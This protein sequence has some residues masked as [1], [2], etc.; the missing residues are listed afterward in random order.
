MFGCHNSDGA[1]ASNGSAQ[2]SSW[3]KAA[4]LSGALAL[5][6]H[7]LC[8][9]GL[10]GLGIGGY[11]IHQLCWHHESA[12]DSSRGIEI[13]RLPEIPLE[14]K[15]FSEERAAVAREALIAAE[16]RFA[17]VIEA[18]RLEA[19]GKPIQVVFIESE[20]NKALVVICK[21]GAMCPCSKPQAYDMGA[22][23][24]IIGSE[25]FPGQRAVLKALY[26]EGDRARFEAP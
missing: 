11:S 26:D 7:A 17:E 1:N 13:R 18:K 12:A 23:D 6:P 8:V 3:Y 19:A 25:Q 24:D 4:A 9:I 21:E 5:G 2:G 10:G 22:R 16:P 15:K 20:E 14:Y